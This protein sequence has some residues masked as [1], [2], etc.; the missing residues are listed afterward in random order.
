MEQIITD[1]QQLV[2][3]YTKMHDKLK[4]EGV[5][6]VSIKS[7]KTKTNEQ[8]GYYWSAVVPTITK[9]LNERGLASARLTEADVNEVL[10]RKFFTNNVVIDGEMQCLPRSKAEA[11]KEEM[12]K[13]LEDVLMWASNMEIDVPPPLMEDVF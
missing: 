12:S 11:T 2:G 8:L 3:L 9:A 13:F 10:N 6:K 7:M 5:I 4:K 1:K